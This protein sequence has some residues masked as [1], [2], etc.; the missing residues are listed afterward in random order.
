[1]YTRTTRIFPMMAFACGLQ[2]QLQVQPEVSIQTSRLSYRSTCLHIS[3]HVHYPEPS[4]PAI[5][6]VSQSPSTMTVGA[7]RSEP[8]T[9]PLPRK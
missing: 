5:P 4:E 9:S 8:S 1:M 6:S 3:T 2:A 7:A